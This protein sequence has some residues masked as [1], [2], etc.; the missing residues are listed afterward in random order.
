MKNALIISCCLIFLLFGCSSSKN[1]T[2]KTIPEPGAKVYIELNNGAEFTGEL[3]SVRNNVMF[4]CERY[5]AREKDLA[6][7]VYTIYMIKNYDIKLIELSEGNYALYCII[8][9]GLMGSGIGAAV[10]KGKDKKEKS[11]GII[12]FDL[13]LDPVTGCC[14]GGLIGAL[15]GGA[16]GYNIKD[17]EAVYERADPGLYDFT[18]LNVYARYKEEPE[19]LQKI[20]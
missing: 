10:Y 9:G 16:I 8:F 6:D 20:E 18:Q 13:N 7:S 15:A 1:V 4:V 2:Y 3:L 19:Y 14:V 17:Y 12:N 5:F 11:E